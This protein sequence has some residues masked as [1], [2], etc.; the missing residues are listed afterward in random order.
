MKDD[1]RSES[2]RRR[3]FYDIGNGRKYRSWKYRSWTSMARQRAISIRRLD[4]R[5]LLPCRRTEIGGD[6]KG[7]LGWAWEE[8][9]EEQVPRKQELP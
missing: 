6:P 5:K 4:P 1:E 8:E 3:C 7:L 9:Q 2:Q